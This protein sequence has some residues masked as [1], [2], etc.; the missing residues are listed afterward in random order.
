MESDRHYTVNLF[1]AV[2]ITEE[3]AVNSTLKQNKPIRNIMIVLL[4]QHKFVKRW[5][6]WRHLFT[7]HRKEVGVNWLI[8]HWTLGWEP[9]TCFSV[10]VLAK[11]L[12]TLR[13]QNS[14]VKLLN[15]KTTNIICEAA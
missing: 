1:K 7:E 14:T 3:L 13:L 11:A 2:L 8:K 5:E 12:Q 9:A 6:Q 4:L 10:Q 15:N